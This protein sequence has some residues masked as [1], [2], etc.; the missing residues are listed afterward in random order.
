MPLAIIHQQTGTLRPMAT[1]RKRRETFLSWQKAKL[2]KTANEVYEIKFK[3][4]PSPQAK[5]GLALG[6]SQTSVS[7][8]LLGRYTP[9]VEVAEQIAHL[10][11][12][13]SLKDLIGE[14]YVPT[15]D[16]EEAAKSEPGFPGLRACVAYHGPGRWPE[17]VIAAAKAGAFKDDVPAPEWVK[18]LDSIAK[19][20][21]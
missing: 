9:S 12:I 3:G 17:W 6:L 19:K 14:Y 16:E 5:M 21:G 4:K 20:L 15:Q 2:L 13:E 10:A 11:G 1:K 8:L 7:A 18:R